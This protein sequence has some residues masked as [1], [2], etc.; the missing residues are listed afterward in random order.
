MDWID[1][2]VVVVVD[3]FTYVVGNTFIMV[4]RKTTFAEDIANLLT[5]A[6]EPE[7]DPEREDLEDVPVL[8]SSDDELVSEKPSKGRKDT[9]R[10]R[11]SID[12]GGAAEVYTGK[13]SSRKDFFQRDEKVAR[14]MLNREESEEEEEELDDDDDDDV[15]RTGRSDVNEEADLLEKEML[16]VEEA[17]AEAAE[18]M[19]ER[20][21]K[22]YRKALCVRNQKRLWNASLEAR[23]MMQ[24]VIQGTNMLP[25]SDM[26]PFL[27]HVDASLSRDIKAVSGDARDTLVDMCAVLDALA[28]NNPATSSL[29]KKRKIGGDSSVDECWRA[30]DERYQSFSKYRDMCLDRWHRKTILSAGSTQSLKILN[31]GISKQVGLLMKD[32]DNIA[33]RSRVPMNQYKGLCQLENTQVCHV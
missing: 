6:P 32:R 33:A 3:I 18:E 7:I 26:H 1:I 5:P 31:Q 21:Q 17:E 12:L 25:C 23:I 11:G 24:R 16:Q 20:A 19:R 14:T 22:E 9:P 15:T 13:R 28:Q 29:Q 27:E 8:L 10:L 30:L 2:V 4:K